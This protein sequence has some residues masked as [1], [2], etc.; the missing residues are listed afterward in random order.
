MQIKRYV[1]PQPCPHSGWTWKGHVGSTNSKNHGLIK[2]YNTS[3]DTPYKTNF[4]DL[5]LTLNDNKI[6]LSLYDKR[7]S[8]PFEVISFPDLSGNL[9]FHNAHGVIIG[10][11]IRFTQACD[12]YTHF[13]ARTQNLTT[14]L[15]AQ[16]FDR[17]KL[18][19]R[20]MTFFDRYHNMF[21]KYGV[22]RNKFLRD[23]FCK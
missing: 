14:R 3:A 5:T 21:Q 13:R 9:H 15:I 18:T 8:F 22:P 2:K 19:Q 17:K 23:C 4:L 6:R 12:H 16:H 7:D 1:T 20:C 10:Q 11:L